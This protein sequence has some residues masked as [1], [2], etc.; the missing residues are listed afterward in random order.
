MRL[1]FL[2]LGIA[3]S[4]LAISIGLMWLPAARKPKSAK[5]S[6]VQKV[7][8]W[9]DSGPQ[10]ASDDTSPIRFETVPASQTGIS[11]RYYGNPSPEHYMTEQNGGGVALFDFEGD[12]RLDVFLVNGSH[13]DLPAEDIG[14]TNG[15]FRQTG[16]WSFTD[17]TSAT[18]L[19]AHGFG[20]GCAVGDYD[21]D[22]FADVFVAYY[23]R[24][25]LW[26]NNGDGTFSDVTE[27]SG[28]AEDRWA[29]STAF[30]DLDGG[31][32]P[33]RLSSLQKS[34]KDY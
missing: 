13:F 11:F 23:G 10:A 18:G 17:V 28:I 12:G 20:Q 8:S 1:K 24:S 7:A 19:V 27:A 21:N 26:R 29:T 15:L 30:A 3:A 5:S 33:N 4:I 16:D 25:R 22:G 31:I 14:A 32:S 6:S 2:V 34:A 9:P